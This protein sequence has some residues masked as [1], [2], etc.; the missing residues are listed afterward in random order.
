MFCQ[1]GDG[2][3]TSFKDLTKT[4]LKDYSINIYTGT[5]H[6]KIFSII[7]EPDESLQTFVMQFSKVV[8][9]ITNCNDVVAILAFKRGLTPNSS[10]LNE[11]SN[12]KPRTIAEALARAQSLIVFFFLASTGHHV[13]KGSALIN[14]VPIPPASKEKT[15]DREKRLQEARQSIESRFQ[16]QTAQ[17]ENIEA[18]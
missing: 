3:V 5:T 17:T 15:I 6:K 18:L 13:P 7:Q 11:I 9:E 14:A 10:F 16:R 12:R 2:S 1:L 4:F 8:A